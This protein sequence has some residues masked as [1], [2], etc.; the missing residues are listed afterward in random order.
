MAG[1]RL[2]AAAFEPRLAPALTVF[3]AALAQA[4]I[5]A[6][7]ARRHHFC[8][9]AANALRLSPVPAESLCVLPRTTSHAVAPQVWRRRRSWRRR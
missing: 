8:S 1:E 7:E 6:G 2:S 5:G 9:A 4:L 3:A